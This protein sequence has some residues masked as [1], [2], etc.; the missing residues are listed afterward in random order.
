[1]LIKLDDETFEQDSSDSVR[2]LILRSRSQLNYVEQVLFK[3]VT[4]PNK[5]LTITEIVS[6]QLLINIMSLFA[7]NYILFTGSVK[8]MVSRK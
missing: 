2:K 3:L 4:C 7:D 5:N 6:K 8:T 1:M